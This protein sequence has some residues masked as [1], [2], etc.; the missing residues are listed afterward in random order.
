MLWLAGLLALALVGWAARLDRARAAAPA[1]PPAMPEP[2]PTTVLL[3]V[4]DEED[5]V[6]ACVASLLAQTARPAVVVIDDASSDRTREIAAGMMRD[7][8]E[9]RV[10]SA[11]PLAPGWRGKLNALDGALGGVR[12]PW[13][14]FTDADT[15]HAPELLARAHA[16]AHAWGLDAVSIA[17]TQEARSAG[18]QF[19]IPAVFGLLDALLG[20]WSAAAWGDGPAIA[21]GQFI[22]VR[23]Q[24][25]LESGGLEAIRQPPID[26]VALARNLRRHGFRTGFVR[27]PDLLRVRMYSGF[28]A[29]VHGW[30]RN[31]GGIFGERPLAAAALAA[32]LATPATLLVA[33][34]L[35]G[36]WP[37]LVLVW[38]A[39]AAA[40]ASV[41]LGA[42]ASPWWA[43]AAPLDGVLLAVVLGSGVL[44]FRRG[45]LVRW[46]GREMP[47]GGRPA[48][49]QHGSSDA[50][51]D[52][53]A[54]GDASP[55][56]GAPSGASPDQGAPRGA[57]SD[58]GAPSGASSDQ[59]APRGASNTAR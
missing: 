38:T 40:S 47:V 55:D 1:P 59:S 16:A 9:V 5:N 6:A 32:L 25:L 26:D 33:A 44:D 56:Q 28:A 54:P 17:G 35:A 36:R 21:N 15:R 49:D 53:G 29:A 30:R 52:Q 11:R 8:P 7:T 51:S 43:L 2:P 34:A 45:R 20:D 50:S 41:R 22:L 3:P 4:R 10:E 14:L 24:A 27:A 57:S 19:L 46:K 31:L 23:R 42:G 13:I 58:Q 12:D 18:E 39:A 37:E 48:A